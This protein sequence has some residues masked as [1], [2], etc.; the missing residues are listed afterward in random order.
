[1]L[2]FLSAA[3]DI[4]L[5]LDAEGAVIGYCYEDPDGVYPFRGMNAAQLARGL[6]FA[7]IREFID[8]MCG[9]QVVGVGAGY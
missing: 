3:D 2:T 4:C 6:G 5:V 8:T 7:N 9:L 1:M